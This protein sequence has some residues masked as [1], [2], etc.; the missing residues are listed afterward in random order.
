MPEIPP[1]FLLLALD[2]VL[3]HYGDVAFPRTL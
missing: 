2:I 3:C 1:I